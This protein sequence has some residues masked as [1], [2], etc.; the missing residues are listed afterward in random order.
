MDFFSVVRNLLVYSVFSLDLISNQIVFE[1]LL[2]PGFSYIFGCNKNLNA[3]KLVSSSPKITFP[4]KK[5][6]GLDECP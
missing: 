1:S 4:L 3:K 6:G 2:K 5:L